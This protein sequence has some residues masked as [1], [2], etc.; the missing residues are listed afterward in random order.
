MDRKLL[1]IE[2]NITCIFSTP[3]ASLA[4]LFN[5][6]LKRSLHVPSAAFVNT[7][8]PTINIGTGCFKSILDHVKDIE[9]VI[10]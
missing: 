9:K 6:S 8:R 2:Y 5:N 4:S 10:R 1:T 3:K 7:S